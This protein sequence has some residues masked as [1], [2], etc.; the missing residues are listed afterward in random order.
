MMRT[1]ISAALLLDKLKGHEII[2]EKALEMIRA[3]KSTEDYMNDPNQISNLDWK[4]SKDWERPWVKLVKPY[5]QKHFDK[6]AEHQGYVNSNIERMWYQRYSKPGDLHNWHIHSS[7]YTGVYYLKWA[8]NG[9]G[10]TQV[11]EP[12]EQNKKLVL[13]VN[14]GDVVLFPSF[15]IHRS[16]KLIKDKE[17]IIISFNINFN[18]VQKN[19]FWHLD[20][21]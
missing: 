1:S 14:E 2:Q 6:C 16:P 3:D 17:K 9:D 21:I 19:I 8:D 18:D 12:C 13:V 15:A 11:V 5:L 10:E 20:H 4:N 7:S